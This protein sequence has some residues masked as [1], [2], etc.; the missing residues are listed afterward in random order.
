MKLHLIALFFVLLCCTSCQNDTPLFRLL[1]AERTGVMF[2]NTITTTDS[3]N[4]LYF[5]YIYNGGGV[6]MSDLNDDGLP[7]L[8]FTGNQVSSKI[9]I[10]KGDLTFEDITEQAGLTTDRWCTGVAVADVNNDGK[11][12]VYISVAGYEV[13]DEEMENLLFINQGWGENGIPVFEEQAAAY[14]LNDN[15]YSTQG[16]FFDYDKDGDLDLYVLTNAMETFDRNRIKPKRINGEAPSTDRLYRNNGDETFTDVSREAGILI[17]GYGLGVTITDIDGNGHPDIYVANDFLSNDLMWMNNGD[18]IF[19]DRA[20][21]ALAHQSH[22]GMGVDVADF[23]NDALPDI[24]VLDMLPE[25]NYRQKMMISYVDKDKFLL[26]KDNGYQDQYMR[27]TVQLQQGLDTEGLPCFS[28]IGNATGMAATDWSWSVLF[29]DFD[30]DSWKDVYITNGYRKD[31]T[32]LD[33]VNYSNYNQLFGTPEAREQQAIADLDHIADV[34]VSNYLFRNL[35]GLQFEKTSSEWGVDIPSFSNGAAYGDL[36][37]DGDLDLVVNNMD[38]PA[39]IFENTQFDQATSN[40]L[41]IQL[42]EASDDLT[43]YNTKV[44]LFTS[45]QQQ[46]QE[47]APYR[48]YKSTMYEVLHFGLGEAE[49]VDSLIV[50]WADG[51][52][53]LYEKV[54][55]NQR[56]TI[57]YETDARSVVQLPTQKKQTQHFIQAN[58]ALDIQFQHAKTEYSSLRTI[59]TLPYNYTQVGPAIAVGDVNG[60]NRI[61]FFCGGNAEQAGRLFLQ[62]SASTFET[63]SFPFDSLQQDVD[64]LFFDV[65]SDEDLDLYI[66][67]G[68]T[69]ASS[70]SQDRLYTNDGNGNFTKAT[71]ALPSRTSSASCV[72]AADFDQ[73]GDLDVF[74]G[75]HV[76]PEGYPSASRSYLLENENGTFKDATPDALKKIGIVKD[77]IWSDFDQD[78]DEDLI[79]VGEWMPITFLENKAGRLLLS[80]LP[81]GDPTNSTNGWWRHIQAVDWNRDGWMDYLVGNIGTNSKLKASSTTPLRLYTN[82]FDNNQTPDPLLAVT[83]QEQEHLLHERDR[84]ISQIPGMKRR[85]PDYDTYAKADLLHTLSTDE[86]EQ[87]NVLEANELAS[88]LLL[89]EK[90]RSF[91]KQSLP[92]QAQLS[93]IQSSCILETKPL[94]VLAVGND[95]SMET[96]QIGFFDA[97]YGALLSPHNSFAIDAKSVLSYGLDASGDVRVVRKLEL[98]NGKTLILLG[99]YGGALK[100]YVIDDV[101]QIDL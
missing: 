6:A 78:G 57:R 55:A 86:L 64:A 95:F 71:K 37:N 35:G 28:E 39:F 36:D 11:Q 90:G 52:T 82:D 69:T 22:N 16:A 40:Y 30:N 50:Q 8:I 14:G 97:S 13:T 79:V 68:A 80:N 46:L 15:G 38:M 23:N 19:T 45:G 32:N 43:I 54:A 33:Y 26:K 58:E 85:F 5:E 77:A 53:H 49:R 47:Y 83:I 48:G 87:T 10:N 96:N 99:V 56:L 9:Y 73:D 91:A 70:N 2:E 3:L 44:L 34:E 18:G 101:K 7:D 93:T 51:I 92:I 81:I 84:L 12:D 31:I 98:A 27:N 29:A 74:V 100:A 61:D 88:M 21:Q 67:S 17:E 24:A 42:E 76:Q 94:S 65:D 41:Q 66:V 59:R 62:T 75:G 20:P 25:D 4:A 89:N 1:P 60:D 72:R 63:R